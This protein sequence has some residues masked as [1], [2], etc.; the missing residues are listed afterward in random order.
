MNNVAQAS[1][2]RKPQFTL[3]RALRSRHGKVAELVYRSLPDVLR[4]LPAYVDMPD[5]SPMIYR[6]RSYE[7]RKFGGSYGLDE[8]L[9]AEAKHDGALVFCCVTEDKSATLYAPLERFERLSRLADFGHGLQRFLPIKYWD[10]VDETGRA[11][12]IDL[13]LH[14]KQ[15]GLFEG[16]AL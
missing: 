2:A 7:M 9:I 12:R 10:A 11:K 6:R 16:G 8:A 5:P 15:K 3:P 14:F 1:Y 13:S 4:D